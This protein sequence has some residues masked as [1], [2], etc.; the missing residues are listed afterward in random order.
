MLST[1]QAASEQTTGISG[2][3]NQHPNNQPIK[4]DHPPWQTHGEYNEGNPNTPL[5]LQKHLHI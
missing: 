3:N 2:T 1:K 4:T 5:I